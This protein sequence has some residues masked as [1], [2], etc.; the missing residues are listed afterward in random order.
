MIAV[1]GLRFENVLKVQSSVCGW[2]RR[3]IKVVRG[4]VY[5]TECQ[6]TGE[7]MTMRTGLVKRGSREVQVK[8]SNV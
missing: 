6:I 2:L 5:E 3:L 7:V 8:D 4:A 1:M